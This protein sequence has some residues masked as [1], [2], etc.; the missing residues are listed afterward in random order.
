MIGSIKD[1]CKHFDAKFSIDEC[2]CRIT[3][4]DGK[5]LKYVMM[6]Y[7]LTVDE[8]LKQLKQLLADD[9]HG[10]VFKDGIFIGFAPSKKSLDEVLIAVDMMV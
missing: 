2:S 4:K 10:R 3:F 6:N 7:G 8:V 9:V 1:I 5:V